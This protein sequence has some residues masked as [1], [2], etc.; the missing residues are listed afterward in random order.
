MKHRPKVEIRCLSFG[1]RWYTARRMLGWLRGP[2]TGWS[3]V[4]KLCKHL[5][6]STPQQQ[7]PKWLP[8]CEPPYAPLKHIAAEC[9]DTERQPS[10]PAETLHTQSQAHESASCCKQ[11]SVIL[12]LQDSE[13]HRSS[14]NGHMPATSKTNA[15]DRHLPIRSEF[16]IC[17]LNRIAVGLYGCH[18]EL[19]VFAL[20]AG[21]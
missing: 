7:Y 8:A 19:P 12:R 1:I 14:A 13:R 4:Q 15:A 3:M 9:H 11:N 10:S 20:E 6:G 18:N 16:R 2:G 17:P 21:S 5:R